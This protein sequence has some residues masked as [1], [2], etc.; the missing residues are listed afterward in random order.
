M[1]KTARDK[2]IF[3]CSVFFSYVAQD[4]SDFFLKFLLFFCSQT[5]SP[6]N[7]PFSS[8]SPGVQ[9]VMMMVMVMMLMAMM[10]VMMVMMVVVKVM[11]FFFISTTVFHYF[12]LMAY[13]LNVKV[14]P[15]SKYEQK[16]GKEEDG[17]KFVSPWL[18]YSVLVH[19]DK[20]SIKHIAFPPPKPPQSNILP[21]PQANMVPRS[22]DNQ[23]ERETELHISRYLSL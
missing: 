11:L 6:S 15:V 16:P 10:M 12:I 20:P 8:L 21:L 22:S 23:N 5:S 13:D 4:N 19:H 9:V 2:K 17:G 1:Y 7:S 18:Q 3:Y 14:Q